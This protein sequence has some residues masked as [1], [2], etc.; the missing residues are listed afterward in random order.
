MDGSG[1]LGHVR[2]YSGI[3]LELGFHMRVKFGEKEEI[4]DSVGM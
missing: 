1:L 4:L 2:G 3:Q